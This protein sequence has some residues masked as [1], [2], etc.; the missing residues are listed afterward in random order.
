MVGEEFLSHPLFK[1]I[2]LLH[3][4][5]FF[6]IS[7]YFALSGIQKRQWKGFLK[8]GKRQ[9]SPVFAIGTLQALITIYKGGF[10]FTSILNCYICLWFLWSLFE[11]QLCAHILLSFR[12]PVWRIIWGPLPLVLCI[13]LP[14]FIP[15]AEYLSYSWTFFLI[16]MYC[17]HKNFSLSHISSRLY[18]AL[19][20][21]ILAFFCFR[22]D[23]YIY[24]SP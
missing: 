10:Q 4:P 13:I 24:F 8:T 15:Y 20:V 19:P 14:D 12:H 9:L 6:F 5:V 23:W 22:D 1:G 3:L 2:Y 11:C 21:A 16:G 17:R 7:G 18:L